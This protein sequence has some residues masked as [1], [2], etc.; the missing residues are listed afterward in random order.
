[1]S[2]ETKGEE[3]ENNASAELCMVGGDTSAPSGDVQPESQKTEVETSSKSDVVT[4]S[5]ELEPKSEP[6]GEQ[7]PT[8][9]VEEKEEHSK[10]EVKGKNCSL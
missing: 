5:S 9:Y 1:M 4:A 2:K 6:P 8:E 3:E 7:K 10:A